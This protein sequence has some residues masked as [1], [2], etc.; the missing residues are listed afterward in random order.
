M[1]DQISD[2]E[3]KSQVM[4]FIEVAG[5]KFD[6]LS[7]DIRTATIRLD[8]IEYRFDNLDER[9]DHVEERFDRLE[10]KVDQIVSKVVRHEETLKSHE[11]RVAVLEG[12]TH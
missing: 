12:E 9:F 6:G 7:S 4:R 8:K 11:S 3:F 10:T 1:A 5:Q 2:E